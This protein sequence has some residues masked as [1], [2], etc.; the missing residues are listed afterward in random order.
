MNI[1]VQLNEGYAVEDIQETGFIFGSKRTFERLGMTLILGVIHEDKLE[2]L[3]E[4]P[5]VLSADDN[6]PQKLI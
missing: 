2:A 4:H 3:R 6:E 1:S 5:A